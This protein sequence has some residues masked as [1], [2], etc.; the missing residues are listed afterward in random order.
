MF[1][2][3]GTSSST[4]KSKKSRGKQR[5]SSTALSDDVDEDAILP[6]KKSRTSEARKSQKTL[7]KS[8]AMEG[9]GEELPRSTPKKARD[10]DFHLSCDEAVEGLTKDSEDAA[11]DVEMVVQSLKD[12]PTTHRLKSQSLMTSN[13]K[14]LYEELAT[15]ER[16]HRDTTHIEA[17]IESIN[18]M[19]RKL[20]E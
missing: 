16:L 8:A 17:Q 11:R 19:R 4:K 9:E 12:T 1:I 5:R 2:A 18:E 3:G 13:L 14:Q 15:L 6:A 7:A 20:F 10:K